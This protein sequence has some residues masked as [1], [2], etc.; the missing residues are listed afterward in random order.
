MYDI[1]DLSQTEQKLALNLIQIYESTKSA[2][3]EFYKKFENW[4]QIYSEVQPKN[5]KKNDGNKKENIFNTNTV[6]K[7]VSENKQN[8]IN[9][10][11]VPQ[12]SFVQIK[13]KGPVEEET[14]WR[15]LYDTQLKRS[16]ATESI[17]VFS[18]ENIEN[19]YEEAKLSAFVSQI[20]MM[21][22]NFEKNLHYMNEEL[23]RKK[24]LMDIIKTA[25][26]LETDLSKLYKKN[27][28]K[29]VVPKKIYEGTKVSC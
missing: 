18:K 15:A 3:E 21:R 19:E 8:D 11:Q 7:S 9:K 14:I 17:H 5:S 13:S 23:P 22:N 1:K 25:N 29:Y 24:R 12:P 6:L 4:K 27:T 28:D 26:L 10:S 20:D 16:P 2:E